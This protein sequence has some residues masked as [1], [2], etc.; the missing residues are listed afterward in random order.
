MV[1]SKIVGD[2]I[3]SY[4][5][6]NNN[7]MEVELLNIGAVIRSI[8]VHDCNKVLRDVVLGYED[9]NEYK[10]NGC[11]FGA[12]VGPIAN[13]TKSARFSVGGSVIELPVNEGMNNLHSDFEKGFH[14]RY[15]DVCIS[16]DAEDTVEFSLD[17]KDGDLNFPGNRRFSVTY[18]LNDQ[19]ELKMVYEMVTD[20]PTVINPTNHTYFNLGGHDS[21]SI[22]NELFEIKSHHIT[23]VDSELIPLG[24]LM[25]VHDTPFD[26]NEPAVIGERIDEDYSEMI[27]T[28]GFDHNYARDDG[29][30]HFAPTAFLADLDTGI[31]L[32]LWTDMPGVQFYT[33]N[34]IKECIGKNGAKYG[35]HS[36]CCLE[37]QYFPNSANDKSFDAP[38]LVPG[39]KFHSATIY[40]FGLL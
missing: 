13:R 36:G 19:N 28:G 39:E 14:K 34:N 7:G 26:F 30:G 23:P 3:I 20:Q 35:K 4:T 17:L 8:K 11:F 24:S 1:T 10:E 25:P 27:F 5:I 33:G 40:K 18:S 32:E 29:K 6:S 31:V 16:E 2:K 38:V 21:G 12:V 37:T 15:F 9:Y 22:L